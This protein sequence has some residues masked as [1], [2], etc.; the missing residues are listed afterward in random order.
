MEKVDKVE[1]GSNCEKYK[2]QYEIKLDISDRDKVL[3]KDIATAFTEF[4]RLSLELKID[5][6]FENR[7]GQLII[8]YYDAFSDLVQGQWEKQI[9]D[10]LNDFS[11]L[12]GNIEKY[13]NQVSDDKKIAFWD[14]LG[15]LYKFYMGL[16]GRLTDDE[17]YNDKLIENIIRSLDFD[18][19][20]FNIL[21]KL[22][23]NI[24]NV[25]KG[26]FN[27]NTTNM[28]I[29]KG[30]FYGGQ[31]FIESNTYDSGHTQDDSQIKKVLFMYSSLS[32]TLT[33]NF[34]EEIKSIKRS[35]EASNSSIL[36]L[37]E[38][39]VLM[40]EITPNLTKHQ[41]SILHLATHG[42]RNKGPLFKDEYGQEVGLDSDYF[43]KCIQILNDDERIL[44]GVIFNACYSA[45]FAEKLSQFV[46]FSI[47][48]MGIIPDEASISFTKTFYQHLLNGLDVEK[49]FELAKLHLDTMDIEWESDEEG[50]EKLSDIPKFYPQI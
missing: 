43:T 32:N 15:R 18:P 13:Q 38:E 50:I 35:K 26:S 34:G 45:G 36:F 44:E 47:G 1:I 33:L 28:N 20:S 2:L 7:D 42:S 22:K 9:R 24:Y 29:N 30:R 4:I 31:K 23:G 19:D 46:N 48:M 27:I 16:Y 49:C 12:I 37:T 39:S 11:E 40:G 8:R 17:T 5:I 41:P 3:G 14:L 25:F 10:Q 21:E 6:E